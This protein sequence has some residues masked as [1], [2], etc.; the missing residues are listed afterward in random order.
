MKGRLFA[1]GNFQRGF[2]KGP[3]IV[4]CSLAGFQETW[5][6][7]PGASFEHPSLNVK[8][9]TGSDAKS[10]KSVTLSLEI[11]ALWVRLV[12]SSRFHEWVN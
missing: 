6:L 9:S 7:I 5:L 8:Y 4:W 2:S 1:A 12:V 3:T 11:S 10:V